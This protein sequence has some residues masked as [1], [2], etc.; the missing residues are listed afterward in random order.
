MSSNHGK[1]HRLNGFASLLV[2]LGSFLLAVLALLAIMA[3][4]MMALFFVVVLYTGVMALSGVAIDKGV[5]ALVQ[6]YRG[7]ARKAPLPAPAPIPQAR[8]T[9]P[10]PVVVTLVSMQGSC[11]RKIQYAVGNI[12]TFEDGVVTPEMCGPALHGLRPIVEE[13]R[14]TQEPR[15]ARLQCP[16]SGSVMV[17]E[18]KAQER[19]PTRRAA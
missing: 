5:F 9:V 10:T 7:V 2:L 3:G 18:V 6:S 4:P 8:P 13:V 16:L 14:S 1:A 11:A 15:T 12:F 19:R 17:F